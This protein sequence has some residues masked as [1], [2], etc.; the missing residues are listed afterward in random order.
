M[1]SVVNTH[2]QLEARRDAAFSSGEDGPKVLIVGP[3]DHG[4]S[5]TAR[6]LAAY[7]TRLDRN[8]IFV[9]LDVGQG[10][11]AI[12]G[13]ISAVPLEKSFLNVEVYNFES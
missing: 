13:C 3:T 5:T 4:K 2:V 12:P 9:D 10:S 8:P 1:V 11:I 7:A 6:L